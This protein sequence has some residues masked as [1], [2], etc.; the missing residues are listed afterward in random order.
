MNSDQTRMQQSM[1]PVYTLHQIGKLPVV[2]ITWVSI[3]I[4]TLVQHVL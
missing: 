1:P 4:Q 3:P 2:N